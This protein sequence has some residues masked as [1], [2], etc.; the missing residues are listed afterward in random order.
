[1]TCCVASAIASL[2]IT[3]G[4]FL[5]HWLRAWMLSWATMMPVVLLAAPW[6]R[7]M[8]ASLIRDDDNPPRPSPPVQ[9]PE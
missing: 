8:V 1:L 3:S 7:V 2:P 4:A 5:V 6:I 9:P